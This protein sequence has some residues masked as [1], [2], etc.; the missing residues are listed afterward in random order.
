MLSH[1]RDFKTISLQVSDGE[2][3]SDVGISYV[4]PI[5]EFQLMD[6]NLPSGASQQMVETM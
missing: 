2:R 4:P 6:F 3:F 5:P 1:I